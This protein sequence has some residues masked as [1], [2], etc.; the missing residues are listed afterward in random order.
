[1]AYM[2]SKDAG[3]SLL[4]D[5]FA[6]EDEYMPKL[7]LEEEQLSKLGDVGEVGS[8][9]EIHCVVRVASV[10]QGQD[11]RRATLEVIEM[12]FMEDEK[13]GAAADRMYPTMRA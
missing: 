8:T 1:M 6:K 7:H 4:S 10:S 12:E 2:N 5:P 13:N 3:G 9:R 11:G